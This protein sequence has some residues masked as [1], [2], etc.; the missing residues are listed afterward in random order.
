VNQVAGPFPFVA[1]NRRLGFQV[2]QPTQPQ[3]VQRSGHGGEGGS[4]KSGDV[5]QVQSLMTQLHG[6]L[7]ALRIQRQP[8]GA[9]NTAS[10]GQRSWTT[11]AVAGQPPVGTAQRNSCFCGQFCQGAMVV[12]VLRNQSQPA[13]LRQTGIG[14]C[15]HG[16]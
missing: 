6:T 15:M 14:V 8:L 9:A 10:I 2:S 3:A 1:L 11:R 12:Q 7:Q 5:T 13:L 4:E 16:V